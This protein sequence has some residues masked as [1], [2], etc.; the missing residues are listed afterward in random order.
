MENEYGSYNA[1][2]QQYM[3]WLRDLIK[4]HVGYKALLYTTDGCGYSYFTCGAI[5]EVYATVDFGASIKNGGYNN[6]SRGKNI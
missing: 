2:D 1:C 4:G 6:N 3:L 5:H